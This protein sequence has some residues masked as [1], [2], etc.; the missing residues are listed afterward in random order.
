MGGLTSSYLDSMIAMRFFGDINDESQSV[1]AYL[2]RLV[3]TTGL[4]TGA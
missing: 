4:L 2:T 1:A 3:E